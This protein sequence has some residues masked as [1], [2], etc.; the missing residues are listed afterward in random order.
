MTLSEAIHF[1]E[2]SMYALWIYREPEPFDYVRD[3]DELTEGTFI[4]F[5][6]DEV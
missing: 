2:E 1:L 6:D 4:R 3:V 5:S